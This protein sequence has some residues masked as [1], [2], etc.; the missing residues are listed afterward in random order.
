MQP[1]VHFIFSVLYISF[2]RVGAKGTG[3]ARMHAQQVW[4]EFGSL[5]PGFTGRSW[6]WNT[7][8]KPERTRQKEARLNE[9]V[10]SK[11]LWTMP[12]VRKRSTL[13]DGTRSSHSQAST[14][15]F[16]PDSWLCRYCIFCR[17][18]I[19]VSVHSDP[20]AFRIHRVVNSGPWSI[21]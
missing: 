5:F 8:G 13:N 9:G 6:S 12:A 10:E 1:H 15:T 3:V 20:L 16:V 4:R 21:I 7:S 2:S 19:S 14:L 11:R 17:P 18:F